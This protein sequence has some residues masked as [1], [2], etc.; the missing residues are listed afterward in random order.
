MRTKIP[1]AVAKYPLGGKI[2]QGET[3]CSEV[4]LKCHLLQRTSLG[5]TEQR[6][7]FLPPG[8]KGPCG[9]YYKQFSCVSP[10]VDYIFPEDQAL[11]PVSLFPGSGTFHRERL[12]DTYERMCAPQSSVPR[13]KSLIPCPWVFSAPSFSASKL[14]GW[15]RCNTSSS[16]QRAEF[17]DR[18]PGSRTLLPT[19]LQGPR[20]PWE[21]GSLFR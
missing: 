9:T 3:H 20:V 8:P 12:L 2:A 17:P 18:H 4:R 5:T 1:L 13:P 19:L 10:L 11:G 15:G 14:P 6:G 7:Q 21:E 16:H